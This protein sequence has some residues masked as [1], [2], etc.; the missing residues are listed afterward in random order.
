MQEEKRILLLL[1]EFQK[2][3]SLQDSESRTRILTIFRGLENRPPGERLSILIVLSGLTNIREYAETS[4]DFRNAFKMYELKAFSMEEVGALIR[5]NASI[6]FDSR[7]VSR[8][9]ELSG[10]NPFL[11]NLLGNDIAARLREYRRPYCFPEDVERVV[12]SQLD[13]R[14]NS[15]VWAF[16]QYLL[17]QGEE[18]HASEIEELPG[19]LALAWT[20][21]TRGSRRAVSVE[22][23][24]AELRSRDVECDVET[25][26]AQLDGGAQNELVVRQDERYAFASGW[27]AEWLAVMAEK[28][29]PSVTPARDRDLVLNRYRI[30]RVMERGGQGTVYLGKDTLMFD[31]P[32]VLKVYP[33]AQGGFPSI[34]EREAR[35]LCSVQHNAVVKCYAYGTDPEKGGVLVLEPV[36][37]QTLRQLLADRPK[38]ASELIGPE[39]SIGVQVKLLEQIAGALDACH[40][41]G[42]VHKDL[43]PENI[44]INQSAGIWLP[45]LID[46]EVSS[47]GLGE[48]HG[49]PTTGPYTAGY[50]APERY[51]CEPRRAVADVYSLGVVGY[52]LLA[53]VCPFPADPL[54]ARDAQQ[55]GRFRSLREVRPDATL[56]L[57]ELVGS[58]L[59]PSPLDRP[60]A[61]TVA[62]ALPVALLTEDWRELLTRG[63]MAYEEG[64]SEAVCEHLEQG[65][66]CAAEKDRRDPEYIELLE[67]LVDSASD[68]G[69]VLRIARHLAQPLFHAVIENDA[70]RRRQRDPSARTSV[71][72]YKSNALDVGLT[73]C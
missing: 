58:M 25:L 52:E 44:V 6:E 11:V 8:I 55:E 53:G 54:Q 38:S 12:N 63:R 64:D 17:K 22:E 29:P 43:K 65:A 27:L 31:R 39:G 67:I 18:D 23:I 1:D 9:A 34:S 47:T 26:K 28:G 66:L 61:A 72:T 41:A 30:E 42:V 15:R 37:G 14:Q 7:A 2:W 13:D 4:A 57:E 50:V 21:H 5:S 36:K 35:A 62:A 32:V 60:K 40:A 69:R 19:I 45:T 70:G 71:G 46:F 16:I 48:E 51:C 3:L 20:L 33:R 49:V 56:R 59:S 24:C 73:A 68:C 10:G